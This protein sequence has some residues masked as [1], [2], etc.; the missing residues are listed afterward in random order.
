[1]GK[2]RYALA[3]FPG[4]NPMF[5]TSAKLLPELGETNRGI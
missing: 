3:D 2:E 1:L 4:S 5:Y